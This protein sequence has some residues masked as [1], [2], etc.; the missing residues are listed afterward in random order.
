MAFTGSPEG[1]GW[2]PPLSQ[3]GGSLAVWGALTLMLLA[4]AIVEVGSQF[5]D[6]RGWIGRDSTQ[7]AVIV[8]ST[9]LGAA[10]ISVGKHQGAS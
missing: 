2:H 10:L 1:V 6:R 8:A 3:I 4:A 7:G 9:V 5:A